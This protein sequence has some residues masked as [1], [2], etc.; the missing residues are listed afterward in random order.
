M[1]SFIEQVYDNEY[2]SQ[3]SDRHQSRIDALE[4]AAEDARQDG[5]DDFE[6]EN[7]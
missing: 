3:L 7:N 1:N 2:W 4:D 6:D 5:E